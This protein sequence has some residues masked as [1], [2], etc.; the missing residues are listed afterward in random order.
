[1]RDNSERLVKRNQHRAN[2][3]IPLENSSRA[4][5]RTISY[6]RLQPRE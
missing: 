6:R 1:L 3:T 5:L 4:F 2:L